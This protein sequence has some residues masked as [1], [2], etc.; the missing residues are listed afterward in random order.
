V[1]DG[2]WLPVVSCYTFLVRIWVSFSGV[3]GGGFP[4]PILEFLFLF[5]GLGGLAGVGDF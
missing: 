3:A 5:E 2:F 1:A 4:W